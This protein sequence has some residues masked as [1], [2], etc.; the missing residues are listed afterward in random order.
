MSRTIQ[1]E[2]LQRSWD[3][4]CHLVTLVGDAR[5]CGLPVEKQLERERRLDRQAEHV[6]ELLATWQHQRRCREVR[7]WREGA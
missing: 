2:E 3:Y 6:A 4:L 1:P 5:E 7:G